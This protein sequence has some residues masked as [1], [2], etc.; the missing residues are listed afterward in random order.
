MVWPSG[1]IKMYL[2]IMVWAM[3]IQ[4][5]DTPNGSTFYLFILVSCYKERYINI[6]L[7]NFL[8][9][10]PAL[11]HS[12]LNIL[13]SIKQIENRELVT[14][15]IRSGDAC[16]IY[17]QRL[18]HMCVIWHIGKN[19]V[20]PNNFVTCFNKTLWLVPTQDYIISESVMHRLQSNK[21]CT[22][23]PTTYTKYLHSLLI[24]CRKKWAFYLCIAR[25]SGTASREWHI[26]S[27]NPLTGSCLARINIYSTSCLNLDPHMFAYCSIV[28]NHNLMGHEKQK[29]KWR[30]PLLS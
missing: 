22:Q 30:F 10:I 24:F 18:N 26:L 13:T 3:A 9:E 23:R 19:L 20:T 14:L 29:Q 15:S 6:A 1:L 28:Y 4:P 7:T 2:N 25:H 16:G 5:H 8:G 11:K 12:D 21:E 27:I 17:W